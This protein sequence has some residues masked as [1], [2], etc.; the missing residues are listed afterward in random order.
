MQKRVVSPLALLCLEEQIGGKILYHLI[1]IVGDRQKN[2]LALCRYKLLRTK[3]K[4]N[5]QLRNVCRKT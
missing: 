5:F 2:V 4:I 3:L 1:F